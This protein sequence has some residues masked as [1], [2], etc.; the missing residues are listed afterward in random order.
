[1]KLLRLLAVPAVGLAVAATAVLPAQ[2][3][4]TWGGCHWAR[5]GG[6]ATPPLVSSLTSDC[7]AT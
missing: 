1:M 4:H 3:N 6:A 7:S 5:S 2:A